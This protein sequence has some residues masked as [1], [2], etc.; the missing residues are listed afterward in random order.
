MV[1]LRS[2]L[3][4]STLRC[5]AFTL[6]ELMVVLAI[7]AILVGLS[8][9]AVQAAREAMRAASCR[10]NLHQL[11]IGMTLH[12]SRHRVWPSNGGYA[13]GCD[14]VAVSGATVAIGTLDYNSGFNLL[15]GVGKPGL[16][17]DEQTGC[18]G[19]AILTD[20]E[21]RNSYEQVEF[22]HPLGVFL[23]PSRSRYT[24]ETQAVDAFGQYESGGWP[25]ARTD[26]AANSMVMQNR[27]VV[28]RSRDIGDGLSQTISIGEKAFDWDLH[29]HGSWYYDEPLFS[30][31][32]AGT[33]RAGTKLVP[34]GRGIA[35]K[36]N[37]G[38]PHRGG[39]IIAMMDGAVRQLSFE[40]DETIVQRLLTPD[41]SDV[42]EIGPDS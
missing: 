3:V 25:W 31:G 11:Q 2:S 33:A 15:W 13:E 9:P 34:D 24:I 1:D 32:S 14:V 5:R 10:N 19:Y 17:P 36:L 22:R 8:F 6:L 7:I 23:C 26:F 4:M 42:V 20:V 12:E 38:S 27:P 40:T 37:W 29:A 35:F 18:W 41:Q 28:L 30:G 21:Q 16:R 39:V